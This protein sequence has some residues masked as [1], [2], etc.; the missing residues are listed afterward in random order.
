MPLKIPGR[1]VLEGAGAVPRPL[2]S[3]VKHVAKIVRADSA[4]RADA[5]A[6]GHHPAIRRNTQTPAAIISLARK[7]TGQTEHEPDV[8]IFGKMRSKSIF[9]VIAAQAPVII[10]GFKQ[11]GASIAVEVFH[12][13]DFASLCAIEPAVAVRQTEHF[14]QAAG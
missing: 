14:V 12:A 13:S 5:A 10:Y 7:G 2:I 9:V 11:I 6:S 4:G 8:A 1:Q 3:G